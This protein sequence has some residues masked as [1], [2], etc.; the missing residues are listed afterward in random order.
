MHTSAIVGYL[1]VPAGAQQYD[2]AEPALRYLQ[3]CAP[4]SGMTLSLSQLTTHPLTHGKLTCTTRRL[5]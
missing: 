5:C 4:Q 3:P 2:N 1:P